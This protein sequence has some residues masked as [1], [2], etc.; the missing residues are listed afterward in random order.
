DPGEQS[1]V[2]DANGNF[3][4]ANV[5]PGTFRVREVQ[6]AGT[7]QTSANPA[8]IVASSGTNITGVLF[9]NFQLVSITGIKFNDLNGNGVRDAGEPGLAGITVF[10]DANNNGI[11]DA[12]ERITITDVNGNFSFT[13]VGPGTY[14]VRE[15]LPAG[16]TQ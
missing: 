6:P 3:T 16:S 1:T 2:T 13:K 4:F 5:G 9:G 14:R 7:T 15:M 11:L 12:G 10:L 8:V